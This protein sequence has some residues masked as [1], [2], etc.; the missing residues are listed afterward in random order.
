MFPIGS[1][2]GIFANIYH[3]N[4][5]NVVNTPYMDP[6]GFVFG[7]YHFLP[8]RVLRDA[9]KGRRFYGRQGWNLGHLKVHSLQSVEMPTWDMDGSTGS[10]DMRQYRTVGDYCVDGSEIQITR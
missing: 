3:Q 2:Y 7:A 6:M 4:Q 8:P 10:M 9:K 5:P 1:M